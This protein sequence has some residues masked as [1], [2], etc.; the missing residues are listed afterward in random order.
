M[1]FAKL[2][3]AVLAAPP[4]SIVQVSRSSGDITYE[5]LQKFSARR[6]EYGRP[7]RPDTKNAEFEITEINGQKPAEA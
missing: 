1:T 4:G 2:L 7:S 3:E 6:F 5:M